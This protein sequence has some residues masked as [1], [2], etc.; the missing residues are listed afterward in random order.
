MG[1]ALCAKD[2][3]IFGNKS[4]P[5]LRLF[6]LLLWFI[7][8]EVSDF[9]ILCLYGNINNGNIYFNLSLLVFLFSL[10]VQSMY[11][12]WNLNKYLHKFINLIYNYNIKNNIYYKLDYP[13]LYRKSKY[14]DAPLKYKCN[15]NPNY[16][17]Y[18]INKNSN[19]DNNSDNNELKNKFKYIIIDKETKYKYILLFKSIFHMIFH[20]LHGGIFEEFYKILHTKQKKDEDTFHIRGTYM[21]LLYLH[22]YIQSI[23]IS[24]INI[25]F[26]FNNINTVIEYN[27]IHIISFIISLITIFM[28]LI[29][30]EKFRFVPS[31][32]QDRFPFLA[33]NVIA[34]YF[35]LFNDYLIRIF[36]LLVLSS[37]IIYNIHNTMLYVYIIITILTSFIY[38]VYIRYKYGFLQRNQWKFCEQPFMGYQILHPIVNIIDI[39]PLFGWVFSQ[40]MWIFSFILCNIS[41]ITYITHRPMCLETQH[42][43]LRVYVS[44]YIINYNL[45]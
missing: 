3:F 45:I 5:K 36:P 1:Q 14:I 6:I 43:K 22:C 24:F 4:Y 8:D 13:M 10:F 38:F 26:I 16:F 40:F 27:Y 39:E 17:K 31:Y 20:C 37:F 29:N 41:I 18:F 34:V 35:V 21:D 44:K 25:I 42:F 23:F 28:I 7:L 2:G 12:T 19:N 11:S 15:F 32:Y 9:V 30:F 33:M